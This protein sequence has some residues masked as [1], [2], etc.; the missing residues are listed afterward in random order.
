MFYPLTEPVL[1]FVAKVASMVVLEVARPKEEGL[2]SLS[3]VV[4]CLVV[5]LFGVVWPMF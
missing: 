3:P 1:L 5:V 2:L 4:P